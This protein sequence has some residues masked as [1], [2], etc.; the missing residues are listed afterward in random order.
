MLE[1][2]KGTRRLWASWGQAWCVGADQPSGDTRVRL[3][4]PTPSLHLISIPREKKLKKE[5]MDEHKGER[6]CG[7]L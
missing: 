4:G 6:K 5:S 2:S 3:E 1:V 7:E